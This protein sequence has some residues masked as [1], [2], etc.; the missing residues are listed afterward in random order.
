[1]LIFVPVFGWLILLVF[2][3]LDGTY[4]GNRYGRDPKGRG[5]AEIFR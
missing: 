3:C 2:W 5:T 4:G 1:L